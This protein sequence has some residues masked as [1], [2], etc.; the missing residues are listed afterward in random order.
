LQHIWFIGDRRNR[1]NGSP[2]DSDGIL[3]PP[4][5]QLEKL[6]RSER[7]VLS[8]ALLVPPPARVI[9]RELPRS[10]NSGQTASAIS[11]G[12]LQAP[13]AIFANRKIKSHNPADWTGLVPNAGRARKVEP[14]LLFRGRRRSH[15]G[16]LS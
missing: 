1:C 9:L 10:L 16:P 6:A 11:L 13:A 8:L 12:L 15:L 4:K 2:V 7:K 5:C 14:Q 3:H